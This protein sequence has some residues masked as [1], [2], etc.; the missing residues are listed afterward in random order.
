MSGP[1][2][3]LLR[4]CREASSGRPASTEKA[5]PVKRHALRSSTF[6]S[7]TSERSE[8]EEHGVVSVLS[9]A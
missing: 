3:I 9:V 6:L 4:A 5:K 8:L 7:M 1:H 2:C